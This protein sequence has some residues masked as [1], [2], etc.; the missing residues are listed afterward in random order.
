MQKDNE[1][2]IEPYEDALKSKIKK[3]NF[4]KSNFIIIIKR[5]STTS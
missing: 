1:I 4:F 2:N 3:Y 5:S